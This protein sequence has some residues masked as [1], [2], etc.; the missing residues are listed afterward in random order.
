MGF[1]VTVEVFTR[2]IQGITASG[3]A[4]SQTGMSH[5]LL[6]ETRGS[7]IH[8]HAVSALL[9]GLIGSLDFARSDGGQAMAATVFDDGDAPYTRWL[10]DHPRGLVLNS[11]RQPVPS[12]MVLHRSVCTTIKKAAR[13]SDESPFTAHGYIKVCA[14]D[15]ADLVTWIGQR[16]G[17]GFSKR[18][19]LCRA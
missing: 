8:A 12:Y 14:D 15:L 7:L 6:P 3:T 17:S 19:S 5:S 18:C 1:A 13:Q 2:R 9:K 16:G 11:R 4:P 10:H